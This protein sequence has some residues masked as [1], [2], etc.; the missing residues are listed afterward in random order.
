MLVACQALYTKHFTYIMNT[1][2]YEVD[3]NPME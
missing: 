1:L 3:I 2:F